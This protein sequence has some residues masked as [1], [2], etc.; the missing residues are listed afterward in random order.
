MSTTIAQK[1]IFI[2]LHLIEY[3]SVLL[4]CS[5]TMLYIKIFTKPIVAALQVCRGLRL[6]I[7]HV[8]VQ[9]CLF[10]KT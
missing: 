4:V 1:V 6:S 2:L 3:P 9:S 10:V 8:F 7:V 5:T